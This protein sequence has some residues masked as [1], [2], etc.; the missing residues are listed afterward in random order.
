MTM[1]TTTMTG[2]IVFLLL[3]AIVLTIGLIGYYIYNKKVNSYARTQKASHEGDGAPHDIETSD[4]SKIAAS[5]DSESIEVK[6]DNSGDGDDIEAN[7]R[8]SAVS[9]DIRLAEQR[10][11]ELDEWKETYR[12]VHIRI[13]EEQEE[14]SARAH[15]MQ[16]DKSK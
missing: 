4:Q 16:W 12:Q 3:V 9:E 7:D 5:E 10:L 6:D 1:M 11:R 14:R 8:L 2:I 15:A 13:A